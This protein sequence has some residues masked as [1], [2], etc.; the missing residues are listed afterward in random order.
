MRPA[1]R[2]GSRR[3]TWCRNI[4]L[5]ADP[6]V[7]ATKT[8][9]LLES[10]SE[11]WSLSAGLTQPI[12]EGGTLLHK[13]R[14]AK[15]AYEQAAAQYRSTVLTAFESVADA[16]HALQSDADLL[17]AAARSEQAALAS[18]DIT[19]RQVELGAVGPLAFLVAEPAYQQARIALIQAR[20]SRFADTAALLQALGGGW[21]NRE[22]SSGK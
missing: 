20:A 4:T 19:R 16:L 6:G 13:S 14:A 12:F 3:R 17:Q 8:A 15:A 18:L 9:Q 7:I 11:F 5:T 1:P 22:A 21:W 2:W 10:G